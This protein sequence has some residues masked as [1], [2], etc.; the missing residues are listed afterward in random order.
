MRTYQKNLNGQ[1]VLFL[2]IFIDTKQ[3]VVVWA[4]CLRIQISH[5][6][7]ILETTYPTNGVFMRKS[8]TQAQVRASDTICFLLGPR[9]LVGRF[10]RVI[11]AEWSET[12]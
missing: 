12:E 3:F 6:F 10:L 7:L 11:D 8:G 1:K 2:C 9:A 5:F 4:L